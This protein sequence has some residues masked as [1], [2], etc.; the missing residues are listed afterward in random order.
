M[1]PPRLQIEEGVPA[2]YISLVD[3]PKAMLEG[4]NMPW[5][6]IV[7][8]SLPSGLKIPISPEPEQLWYSTHCIKKI[9]E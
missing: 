2:T 5:C 3:T 4:Y 6:A 8:I 7:S 9:C 1:N